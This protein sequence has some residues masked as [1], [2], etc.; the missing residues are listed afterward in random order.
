MYPQT[1]SDQTLKE[2]I[3]SPV[4]QLSMQNQSMEFQNPYVVQNM[5]QMT[6]YPVLTTCFNCKK[7]IT[8][9]VTSKAG[10]GTWTMSFVL[11]LFTGCCCIPF[12]IDSCQDRIHTCSN[13]QAQLGVFLYKVLG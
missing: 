2:N 12:I 5:T 7:T 11:C 13:C 10:S 8:T 4:T 3:Y 1:Q 9:T 6:P